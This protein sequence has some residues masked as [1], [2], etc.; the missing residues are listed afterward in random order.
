MLGFRTASPQYLS[1]RE[2]WLGRC[3]LFCYPVPYII[4]RIQTIAVQR[5][6]QAGLDGAVPPASSCRPA[7]SVGPAASCY[8]PCVGVQAQPATGSLASLAVAAL[9]LATRRPPGLRVQAPPSVTA[10]IPTFCCSTRLCLKHDTNCPCRSVGWL[11]S[12]PKPVGN[13]RLAKR[14]CASCPRQGLSLSAAL[15]L[16][17]VVL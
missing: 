3:I 13:P 5:A 6:V 4:H 1:M 14:R 16:H 9:A 8:H 12:M 2:L 10:L 11:P 17:P 15:L 7:A